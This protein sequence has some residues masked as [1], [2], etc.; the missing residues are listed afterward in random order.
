MDGRWSRDGYG[1]CR[2]SN[3][4]IFTPTAR[5]EGVDYSG[6][7]NQEQGVDEADFVKTNGLNIYFVDDGVLH[8][9]DVPEFGEINHA[10]TTEVQ[11]T[12]VAMMLNNDSLVVVS[13]V[14]TWNIAD[15]D[16]LQ[17]A[18]GWN[19]IGMVGEPIL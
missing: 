18:M 19:G 6:T 9:M 7:N 14:S 3:H 11:G 17:D 12:P 10:S 1:W 13:S 15:N 4:H 16:P 8:I 5:K 2:F